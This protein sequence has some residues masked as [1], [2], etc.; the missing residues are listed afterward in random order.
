MALCERL[1]WACGR[2]KQANVL[3]MTQLA[4]SYCKISHTLHLEGNR[5][6]F[7][8]R[9]YFSEEEICSASVRQKLLVDGCWDTFNK[10]HSFSVWWA[11]WQWFHVKPFFLSALLFAFFVIPLHILAFSDAVMLLNNFFKFFSPYS[12]SFIL[13]FSA[14]S[15][16]FLLQTFAGVTTACDQALYTLFLLDHSFIFWTT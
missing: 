15:E 6:I 14:L 3:Q 10:H 11:R 12:A 7:R 4:L 13:D 5:Y 1:A 8:D 9:N 2:W 16:H